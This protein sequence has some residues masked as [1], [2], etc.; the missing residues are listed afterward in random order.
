MSGATGTVLDHTHPE[1]LGRDRINAVCVGEFGPVVP[2]Q[3]G[4]GTV[5]FS[6]T[7]KATGSVEIAI[8]TAGGKATAL[9]KWKWVGGAYQDNGGDGYAAGVSVPLIDDN[10]VDSGIV[11]AFGNG[12]GQGDAF[13]IGDTF[14]VPVVLAGVG[15]SDIT[16]VQATLETPKDATDVIVLHHPNVVAGKTIPLFTGV[17]RGTATKG[18]PVILSKNVGIRDGL[19]LIPVTNEDS[20]DA[21]DGSVYFGV[22]LI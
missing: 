2:T 9:F 6:G 20:A 12:V 4:F 13:A 7:P 1:L 16:K 8:T 21:I 18:T 19:L 11:A 22:V 17:H 14:V 15:S 10:D 3:T 5:A